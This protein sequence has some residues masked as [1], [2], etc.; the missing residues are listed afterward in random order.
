MAKD[1]G[2]PPLNSTVPVV[3]N[4]RLVSLVEGVA[5]RSSSYNF[6]LP[7]NQA[8]GVA[9]GRV[10]ASSGSDLYDVA[11]ALKTH[12][13]LFSVN[14]SGAIVTKTQ[15]DKEKQEWY[16]LDVEAV[17]TRSPPTTATAVVRVQVEDVNESPQFHPEVY[18]ASVFSIAPYKTSVTR[19][20][21]TDPDVGEEG[22]LDY[23]LSAE[24]PYFDVDPSSGLVYVVSVAGLA[25]QTAAVEVKA[26]DPRGL[27]ATARV[28]VAVQGNANSGNMVTISLNQPANIVE[29]KVPELEK[30][31][32]SA[33]GW[34]VTIIQ[35]WSS[36]GGSTE[37][38]ALRADVRTMVSFIAA[39]R[40]EVLSS[41]EVVNKL[42]SQSA[43]VSAEL[44][45]VF[46]EGLHFKVE[47]KPQE[48][49]SNHAVVI[50]LG[51]LLALSIVGLIVA[52]TFV[53]RFKVKEKHQDSDKE[54]FDINLKAEGY[55]DR[56]G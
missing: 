44:V 20:N 12:M 23:S 31:L 24:S 6:S 39:D 36:N 15:L 4:L 22:Q 49:A 26:T 19:V 25:G 52:V 27:H 48:S 3:V 41:E 9:V 42:Q 53:I 8:A 28:E 34:T 5:F 35:V 30:S 43:A 50:A 29:K 46:G 18:K 37:S 1:H 10:W 14:A 38:R 2:R 32:G 47:L 21:A 54:S 55:T 51:V 13:D 17:D 33:L 7:E 16:I 45:K 40:E 11:Y 56:R